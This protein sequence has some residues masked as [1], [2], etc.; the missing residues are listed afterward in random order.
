MDRS[1]ISSTKDE[2]QEPGVLGPA[3]PATSLCTS[4]SQLPPCPFI[5][6]GT[7]GHLGQGR[8]FCFLA[9]RDPEPRFQSPPA[10]GKQNYFSLGGCVSDYESECLGRCEIL[11]R[12]KPPWLLVSVS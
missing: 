11:T 1:E 3:L 12:E 10:A 7:R 6:R 5:A 8:Y 4:S 9:T 2:E